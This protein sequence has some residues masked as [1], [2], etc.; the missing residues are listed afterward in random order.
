MKKKQSDST[1]KSYIK[2]INRASRMRSVF[3]IVKLILLLT[4]VVGIPVAVYCLFPEFIQQFKT[5]NGANAF[6]SQYKTASVFIY[7]GLQIFQ[8]L[9]SVIPGQILQFAAGYAYTFML[10]YVYSIIGIAIGTVCTFYLSRILGKDAMHLIFG[11]ERITKF[12]NILNSKKAYVIIFVLYVIPGFPKD[13]I[14]YAAGVS[15]IKLKPFLILAL[16]GRTPALM[17]TIMMGSMFKDGGYLGLVILVAIAIILCIV[18]FLNKD[19]LI[20]LADKAYDKMMG[21]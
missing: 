5:M 3:S 9:V 13:L 11:E 2:D 7:I 14:T 8:I 21:K 15:E 16:V 6:L 1:E 17:A 19:R 18:C 4:L 20:D 10:G 12:V